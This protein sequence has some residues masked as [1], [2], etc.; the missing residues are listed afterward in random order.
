VRPLSIVGFYDPR[1]DRF[2]CY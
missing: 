2:A 1:G